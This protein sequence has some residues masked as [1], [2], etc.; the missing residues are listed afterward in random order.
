MVV[1][2]DC[3]E[4]VTVRTV[5]KAGPNLGKEFL[6]CPKQRCRFFSWNTDLI[7]VGSRAALGPP[8]GH[9]ELCAVPFQRFYFY[10]RDLPVEDQPEAVRL[11]GHKQGGPKNR[12]MFR[13]DQYDNV[14]RALYRAEALPVWLLRAIITING[15]PHVTSKSPHT[16]TGTMPMDI[17]DSSTLDI[18]PS[19]NTSKTGSTSKPRSASSVASTSS[20]SNGSLSDVQIKTLQEA[21]PPAVLEYQKEGFAFALRR[22]GRVLF[23]DEMGLGK[24]LQALLTINHY[25]AEW[26]ALIVCPS[27]LRFGWRDQALL[28]LNQ[29]KSSSGLGSTST[30]TCEHDTEERIGEKDVQVLVKG[31]EN[32]SADARLVIVSYDLLRTQAKFRKTNLGRSYQVQFV[33]HSIRWSPATL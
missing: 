17:M 20:D 26:P 8:A 27:S 3:G 10:V 29:L 31:S 11:G 22:H 33:E 7:S 6:S 21:L 23:G 4:L 1:H 2:C 13:M 16:G 19:F 9:F 28:W 24:S 12:F 15:D 5:R 18:D 32:V 25:R 30:S 14:R